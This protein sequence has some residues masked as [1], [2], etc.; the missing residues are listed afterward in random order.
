MGRERSSGSQQRSG[1]RI[2]GAILDTSSLSLRNVSRKILEFSTKIS[3]LV[4]EMEMRSLS[5]LFLGLA[6]TWVPA[7]LSENR[8]TLPP[9]RLES[10]SRVAMIT[11]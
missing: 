8:S 2:S 9:L 1:R 11:P 4:G 5:P 7:P 6:V 3:S 10:R